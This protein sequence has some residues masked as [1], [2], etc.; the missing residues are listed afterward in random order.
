MYLADVGL[1]AA[2]RFTGISDAILATV[3]LGDLDP[4]WGRK[5]KNVS[6]SVGVQ[7]KSE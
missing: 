2:E 5:A 1:W 3:Q 7:G 6:N 4:V